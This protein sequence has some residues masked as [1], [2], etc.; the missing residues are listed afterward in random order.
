M[1]NKK[2]IIHTKC[3]AAIDDKLDRA[4]FSKLHIQSKNNKDNKPQHNVRR[5]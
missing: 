2:H 1:A 3:M 5:D 4:V